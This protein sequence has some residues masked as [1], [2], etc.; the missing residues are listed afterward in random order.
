MPAHRTKRLIVFDLDKTLTLSK[1]PV[2]DEMAALLRRLL[3]TKKVAV[4]SGGS[5]KQ[6]QIQFVPKLTS[7]RL[8]RLFL[9]PTCG[10]AFYRH[11]TG[12]WESVY[13]EKLTAA[14]KK[15][16]YDAFERM[17]SKAGFRKPET[18]YGELIEDRE[19][20]ITFGAHGSTAPL[21]IKS[22]LDPDRKKRLAMIAVLERLIPEFEIRTGG[23]SSIDVTRKGIDKGYGILQMEK[24]LGIPRS[25]MVFVGDDLG[26]GGNDAPVIATGV[27]VI[28]VTNPEHTKRVIRSMIKRQ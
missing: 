28:A 2:D 9:F 5:F 23:T 8:E 19:T 20:Q 4:I 10:S 18:I 22:V 21:A 27:E 17:F 11:G 24:H 15:R 16:I 3:E 13:L 14:E 7:G 12:G 1:Q 25:E 26:P 6:F